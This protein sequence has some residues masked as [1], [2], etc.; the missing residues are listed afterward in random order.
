MMFIYKTHGK[1]DTA[2]YGFL[3]WFF[4]YE[5][6]GPS[7]IISIHILLTLFPIHLCQGFVLPPLALA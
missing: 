2:T 7:Y 3:T 5:L 6:V 4:L 1:V